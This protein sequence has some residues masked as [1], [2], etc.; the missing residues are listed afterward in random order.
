MSKI[1]KQKIY[2]FPEE[3][4]QKD[5]DYKRLKV[6]YDFEFLIRLDSDEEKIKNFYELVLPSLAIQVIVKKVSPFPRFLCRFTECD[7]D[8]VSCGTKSAYVRHLL[9]KHNS[10][11]PGGGAFLS[12]SKNFQEGGFTCDICGNWFGRLDNLNVHAL[13]CGA[14]IMNI[15][16][17]KF[18]KFW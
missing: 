12:K 17:H 3:D 15:K 11:L 9:V 1:S 2:E 16:N 13:R 4:Y 5:L 18:G 10:E 8:M 7:Y 14:N 6:K